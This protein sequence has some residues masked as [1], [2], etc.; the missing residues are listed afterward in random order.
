M[1]FHNQDQFTALTLLYEGAPLNIAEWVQAKTAQF[2]SLGRKIKQRMFLQDFPPAPARG[3]AMVQ[4]NLIEGLRRIGYEASPFGMPFNFMPSSQVGVLSGA[5]DALPWAIRAKEKGWVEKLV[6]GPNLVVMPENHE[7]IITHPAI[8]VVVTPSQWVSD[9]YRRCAPNL[10][11]KLVEWATGIDTAYW[12]PANTQKELDFLVFN[13]A[14]SYDGAEEFQQIL[15]T[16]QAKKLKYRVLEYG[17]YTQTEYREALQ[18]SSALIYFGIVES[19]GISL[20]EAWACDVPVLVRKCDRWIFL[21]QEFPVSAAP[22]LTDLCGM[23]FDECDFQSSLN[24][25][26]ENI[27]LFEPRSYVL[28]NFTLDRSAQRYLELFIS[29]IGS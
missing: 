12:A 26:L 6:A 9:I 4:A 28:Q 29:A 27:H 25:F 22:Y 7:S 2:I 23:F 5:L 10:D 8:D 24:T 20:F 21:G 18:A 16:L 1:L 15:T 3:P 14:S 19:Q 17:Q 11:G 13:K